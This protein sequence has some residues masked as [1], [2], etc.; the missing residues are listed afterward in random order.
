MSAIAAVAAVTAVAA[1]AAFGTVLPAV[2]AAASVAAIPAVGI[3]PGD[4]RRRRVGPA[5]RV[6]DP[7]SA[8]ASAAPAATTVRVARAAVACGRPVPVVGISTESD[9]VLVVSAV[10]GDRVSWIP[11]VASRAT[12]AAPARRTVRAGLPVGPVHAARLRFAPDP[13]GASAAGN[14]NRGNSEDGEHAGPW[15]IRLDDVAHF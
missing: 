1:D 8:P 15:Q 3:R 12:C 11:A 2:A 14:C 10:I 6:C 13:A 4:S 7:A 5:T 9:R